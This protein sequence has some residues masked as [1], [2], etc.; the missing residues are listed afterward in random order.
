MKAAA[1]CLAALLASPALGAELEG[2]WCTADGNERMIID[3]V[4]LGFNEHT[5]CRWDGDPPRSSPFAARIS[6]AN[7]YPSG[8]QLVTTD[9]TTARLSSDGS[10]PGTI[11]V[12]V[13]GGDPVPFTRCDG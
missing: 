3:A 6:C 11:E 5:V 1:L 8:D 9:P 7:V 10:P 13:E 2:E 4:G 12:R